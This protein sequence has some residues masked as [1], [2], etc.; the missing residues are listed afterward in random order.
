MAEG[1]RLESWKITPACRNRGVDVAWE[2]AVSR[3]R[4]VYDAQL[5]RF[6]GQPI[7]L[8]VAIELER[9]PHD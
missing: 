5:E 7:T 8:T 4:Q 6:D 9:E 2:D 1:L 3:L